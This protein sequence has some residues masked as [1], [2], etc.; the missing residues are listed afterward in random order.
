MTEKLRPPT[1]PGYDTL[2]AGV[3]ELLES[4]RHLAARSVNALMTAAYWEIGRRIVEAEQ[5][6]KERAEYGERLIV[7]LAH[8]LTARFGRGFGVVNLSQ[9]RRFYQTWPIETILQTVSEKSEATGLEV[10]IVQTPS[11]ESLPERVPVLPP[12]CSRVQ[13]PGIR[14]EVWVEGYSNQR[15]VKGGTYSGSPRT[16]RKQQS[17]TGTERVDMSGTMLEAAESTRTFGTGND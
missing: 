12:E 6:G 10:Q 3:V 17:W 7:R 9:M 1:L 4:A 13:N 14:F 16:R 11:E 5:G 15:S 2:H 8:D